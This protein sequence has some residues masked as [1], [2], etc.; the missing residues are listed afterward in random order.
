MK[1]VEWPSIRGVL[2]REVINFMSMWRSA[3]FSAIMQPIVYLLAFGFGFGS[4]VDKVGGLDYLDYVAL[5]TVSTAV[6][7]ASV[8]NGIFGTII[9]WKYQRTYDA[10]LA[11]PVTVAE[12]VTAEAVWIALRAGIYGCAP[13]LIGFL[14]GL[15]PA[16]GMLLVPFFGILTGFGFAAAGILIAAIV[17]TFENTSY[18]QSLVITPMFLLAG[19]FFPLDQLPDWAVGVSQINPL[20]HCVQLVKHSALGFV[21]ED[22]GHVAALVGFAI[23]M[24]FLAVWRMRKRLVD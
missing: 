1:T 13:L 6:L 3:T 21:P 16:W 18:I 24:W 5:G 17:E 4:L 22:I 20:Y 15:D 10:L 19:S 9:K 14:F 12:I 23:L 7:F 11:A 8:F 2:V